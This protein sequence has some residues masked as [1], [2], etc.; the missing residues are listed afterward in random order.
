MP[1]FAAN[2]VTRQHAFYP[3]VQDDLP[4]TNSCLKSDLYAEKQFFLDI[5]Q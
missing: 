5:F 1:E 3:A 4:I 2:W